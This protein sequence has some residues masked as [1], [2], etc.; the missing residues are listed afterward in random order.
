MVYITDARQSHKKNMSGAIAILK[1]GHPKVRILHERTPWSS[2]SR[3]RY[4]GA[5]NFSSI[6]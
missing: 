6:Y 2:I 3:L 5:K 4:G 1:D